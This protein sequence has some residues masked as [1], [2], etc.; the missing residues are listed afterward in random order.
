MYYLFCGDNYYPRSGLGDYRGK[1][2]TLE[3]A[4]AEGKK[5]KN[6]S[7][8]SNDW[9]TVVTIREDGELVEVSYGW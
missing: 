7:K 8:Y 2:P 3:E 6:S 4:E 9:Y 5:L 1:F